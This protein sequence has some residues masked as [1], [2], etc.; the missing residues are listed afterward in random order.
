MDTKE[1]MKQAVKGTTS[2]LGKEIIGRGG[3]QPTP[4]RTDAVTIDGILGGWNDIPR[5][6]AGLMIER[7]GLPNEA[8]ASRLIWFENGVWKRTIVYRDEVPHNFP[9]PHTDVLEQFVDYRVPLDKVGD[10][11][12]YDGS[13]IV[14]RTKGEVSARCDMEEMNYLALNLMH[15]IATGHRTVDDARRTYA[16]TAAAFMMGKASAYTDALQ[17]EARRSDAADVDEVTMTPVMRGAAEGIADA[18]RN[19][20]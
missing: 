15:E 19:K 3:E 6:V 13:V 17:F 2:A 10:I 14:E 5:K 8:T 18:V 1:R 4:G 9:K 12:R 20:T 7:Y 11:A 16:E